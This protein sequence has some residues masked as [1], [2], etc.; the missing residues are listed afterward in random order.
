VASSNAYFRG[1]F[2][3]DC[4]AIEMFSFSNPDEDFNKWHSEMI[5]ISNSGEDFTHGI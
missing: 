3:E 4:M 5:A 2:D 1:Y